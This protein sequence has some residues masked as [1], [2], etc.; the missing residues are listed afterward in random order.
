MIFKVLNEFYLNGTKKQKGDEIDIDSNSIDKLKAM[1]VLGEP[2][3]KDK[4]ERAIIEP[5]EK[6][7][8][9]KKKK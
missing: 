7:T 1:N 4:I 9:R 8:T 3:V 2:I 5:K 6:R